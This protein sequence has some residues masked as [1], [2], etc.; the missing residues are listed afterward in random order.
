MGRKISLCRAGPLPIGPPHA[1]IEG[2]PAHPELA[3]GGGQRRPLAHGVEGGGA[4]EN[5]V[6]SLNSHHLEGNTEDENGPLFTADT[7]RLLAHVAD[8]KCL[9]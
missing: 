9:D 6:I 1:A 4:G 7:S 3:G 8:A 5:R 2:R